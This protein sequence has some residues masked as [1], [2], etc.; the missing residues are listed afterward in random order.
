MRKGIVISLLLLTACVAKP[1]VSTQKLVVEGWIEAGAAPVVYVS[2]TMNPMEENLSVESLSEHVVK[3]A[4]VTIGDGDEEVILTGTASKRFFPP[5]AFTTGRMY[6]QAGKTYTLTVEYGD[7]VAKATTT[8]PAPAA[9]DGLEVVPTGKEEG[10]K[11]IRVR[12]TDNPLTEDYYHFFTKTQGVDSAYIA[13]P[14]ALVS[15]SM[16]GSSPVQMDIA[17]GGSV[18]RSSW[19]G[20]FMPGDR[21]SVKFVNMDRPMYLFWKAFDEQKSFSN[22]PVFSVDDNLPGNVTGGIGYFAGY[23]STVYSVVIP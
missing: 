21:V 3:W 8:I 14:L 19:Q 11:L 18:L 15:D 12:F 2:T 6:G 10:Q 1:P 17:P 23:G 5:Y 7:A 16:I 4:K 13:S 22:V 20:G 9:L